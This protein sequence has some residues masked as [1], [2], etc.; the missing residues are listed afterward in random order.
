MGYGSMTEIF[1]F[2]IVMY[3]SIITG[4]CMGTFGKRSGKA[5]ISWP[6][7]RI[8]KQKKDKAT[9]IPI[10]PYEEALRKPGDRGISTI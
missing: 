5:I 9:V 3:V 8:I 6:K 7:P 4:Y 2:L 10:D 1:I